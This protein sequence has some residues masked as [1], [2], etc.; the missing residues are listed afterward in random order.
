MRMLFTEEGAKSISGPVGIVRIIGQSAQSGLHTFLFVFML[1][2]LNLGLINLMPVPAL[3]GGRLVFV[4]LSG[5]G[6]RINEKREAFVH[7]MGMILLLSLIGLVTLTDIV[8]WL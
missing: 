7:A 1:I 6:I 3:D 8:A 4:A 5:I 2:N